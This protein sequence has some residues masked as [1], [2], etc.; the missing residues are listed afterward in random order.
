MNR[1]FI[2]LIS[3]LYSSLILAKNNYQID[4]ILFTHAQSAASETALNQAVPLLPITKH[5]IALKT[6]GAGLYSILPAAQS[7]L[8]DAYYHLNR[9]PQYHVLG[10]YSWIQASSNQSA[11]ALPVID[12][13]GWH[14]QGTLRVRQGAYYT[15]DADLQGT[16]QGHPH[17]S[18]T[19]SQKQRLKANTAYYLDHPQIGMLVKVHKISGLH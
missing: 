7:G 1:L 5:A 10:H 6:H 14:V 15:L 12:K 4:V 3:I 17:A 11:V 19:V 2:T 9:K 18:F 8:R 13:N 16:L